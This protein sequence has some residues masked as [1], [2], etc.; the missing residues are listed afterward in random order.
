M[1]CVLCSERG[2]EQRGSYSSVLS[3]ARG[4]KRSRGDDDERQSTRQGVARGWGVVVSLVPSH[5]TPRSRSSI[6]HPH[7]LS[8]H[9]QGSRSITTVPSMWTPSCMWYAQSLT[10]HASGCCPV[11]FPHRRASPTFLRFSQTFDSE[12]LFRCASALV[13]TVPPYLISSHLGTSLC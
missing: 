12:L 8:A 5:C 2:E 3:C 10:L 4:K 6:F 7:L 1:W 11:I 9:L 13:R